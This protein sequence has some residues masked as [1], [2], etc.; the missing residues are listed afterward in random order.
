VWLSVSFEAQAELEA[1]LLRAENVE[2]LCT[3]EMK[4]QSA[5][6][7]QL[8]GEL[9]E[10]KGESTS[11]FNCLLKSREEVKELNIEVDLLRMESQ[12][13]EKKGN[14]LFAEVEDRRVEAERE[15]ISLRA[16]YEGLEKQH[17]LTRDHLH[18][19]NA[20]LAALLQMCGGQADRKHMERLQ[21]QVSQ[22]MSQVQNMQIKLRS[23]E[24]QEVLRLDVPVGLY[25]VSLFVEG[26]RL[27][28]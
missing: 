25:Y 22:Y 6:L 3:E 5:R 12:N 26:C 7:Q 10:V 27:L 4:K 8:R 18:Q 23:Y 15:L 14:S 28:Q 1:R 2:Q 20:Q 17:T 19:V 13:R 9:E 16:Q 21:E 24:N 11:Y